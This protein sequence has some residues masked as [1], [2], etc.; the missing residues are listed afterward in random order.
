MLREK[1]AEAIGHLFA[2]ASG[3]KSQMTGETEILGQVKAAYE[4]AKRARALRANA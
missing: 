2:V 4:R 3:L 1:N